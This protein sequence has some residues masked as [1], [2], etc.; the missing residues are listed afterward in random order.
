MESNL[1]NPTSVIAFL[2][3]IISLVSLSVNITR[4]FDTLAT[5]P[6]Y[7]AVA[8]FFAGIFSF[9]VSVVLFVGLA[10]I[11]IVPPYRDSGFSTVFFVL[12]CLFTITLL[13]IGP[14][15]I[16]GS[17]DTYHRTKKKKENSD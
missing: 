5:V 8:L 11:L 2:A 3:L 17:F 14:I 4:H 6:S 10:V 15:L 7:F 16:Y 9:V 1:I 12:F 13:A